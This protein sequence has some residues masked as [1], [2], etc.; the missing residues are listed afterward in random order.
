[1]TCVRALPS[2]RRDRSPRAGR[3]LGREP[4]AGRLALVSRGLERCRSLEM[5]ALSRSSRLVETRL[6]AAAFVLES[7]WMLQGS[8]QLVLQG[9]TLPWPRR[10]CGARPRG[11]GPRPSRSSAC[12][13]SS[14]I[15]A[16]PVSARAPAAAA[17][18]WAPAMPRR[19]DSISALLLVALRAQGAA[20]WAHS[21]R[22]PSASRCEPRPPRRE[23]GGRRS[24]S[25]PPEALAA[26]LSASRRSASASPRAWS[27]SR[28]RSAAALLR[29]FD[30]RLSR[31]VTSSTGR[32]GSDR[33][34]GVRDG[35]RHERGASLA[36]P[37]P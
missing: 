2:R 6:A 29:L 16:W 18:S 10:A 30:Q 32:R 26:A 34:A 4:R 28:S 8:P 21:S 14:R 23:S 15:R 31:A 12:S 1:M 25:T 11:R 22:E 20:F 19:S 5:G 36:A 7:R 37:V 3:S 27:R 33:R 35:P 13:W 9:A 17:V 24:S